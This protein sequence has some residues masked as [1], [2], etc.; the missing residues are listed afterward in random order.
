MDTRFNIDEVKVN[1]W[2]QWQSESSEGDFATQVFADTQVESILRQ[3]RDL[4]QYDP[5][6]GVINLSEGS[7]IGVIVNLKT[8]EGN[9]LTMHLYLTQTGVQVVQY[10]QFIQEVSI[11]GSEFVEE[12]CVNEEGTLLFALLANIGIN[13]YSKGTGTWQLAYTIT[14]EGSLVYTNIACSK[15]GDVLVCSDMNSQAF[16]V[17]NTTSTEYT[18]KATVAGTFGNDV[19]MNSSGSVIAVSGLATDNTVRVYEWNDSTYAQ[20]GSDLVGGSADAWSQVS[21]S[22]DGLTVAIGGPGSHEANTSGGGVRV[23]TYSGGNWD[24]VGTKIQSTANL[25]LLGYSIDLSDSGTVLAVGSKITSGLVR[26]FELVGGA[27]VQQGADLS[28]NGTSSMGSL[29]RLSSDANTLLVLSESDDTPYIY[30][31]DSGSWSLTA[32]GPFS[33]AF[34]GIGDLYLGGVVAA[35]NFSMI[36]DIHIIHPYTLS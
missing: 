8:H 16:K 18:L 21:L 3:I 36:G 27:W 14:D 24:E 1:E 6:T 20:M 29:V 30:S 4:H 23:F 19:A 26:V 32:T 31:Y 2:M 10:T 11:S 7:E 33:I 34:D 25:Q 35:Q 13:V 9:Q 28:N 22:G 5:D 15:S 12:M 17:Y